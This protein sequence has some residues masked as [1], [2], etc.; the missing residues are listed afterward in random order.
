MIFILVFNR[1]EFSEKLNNFDVLV[2]STAINNRIKQISR[3][4]GSTID[5]LN[6]CFEAYNKYCAGINMLYRS[7]SKY[8]HQA[9]N[10]LDK[11]ESDNTATVTD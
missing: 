6:E 4:E 10:N 1:N 7:T 8:L 2:N 9:L 5:A 3:S 11:C